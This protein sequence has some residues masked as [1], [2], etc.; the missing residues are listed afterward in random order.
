MYWN[1]QEQVV[2]NIIL[3]ILVVFQISTFFMLK[4]AETAFR[5]SIILVSLNVMLFLAMIPYAKWVW[6]TPS[7]YKAFLQVA[8]R[9]LIILGLSAVGLFL[10][11]LTIRRL[12]LK[13]SG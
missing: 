10:A 3:F 1:K 9:E 6:K 7:Y 11:I 8:K 2:F 12:F 13:L 5:D 4:S